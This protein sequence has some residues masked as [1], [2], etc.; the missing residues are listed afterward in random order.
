[1]KA[2]LKEMTVDELN[3]YREKLIK[4]YRVFRFNKLMGQLENTLKI[5]E[6]RREIAR[7]NTI[8]REYELG[9]RKENK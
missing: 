6:T 1:M 2:N 8:L 7:V 3:E 5:R 4:D 9:M